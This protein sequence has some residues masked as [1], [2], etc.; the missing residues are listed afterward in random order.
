MHREQDLRITAIIGLCFLLTASGWLSWEYHLMTQIPAVETDLWTMAAGYFLQAAG[1]GLFSVLLRAGEDRADHVLS[2]ALVLHMICMI[3]AVISPH[4]AGTLVFGCLMSLFCGVIAGYYLY[5]LAKNCRE[6][7]KAF[8]FGAGYSISILVQWILSLIGEGAV[9]YSAKILVICLLLT[10][11]VFCVRPNKGVKREVEESEQ[12]ETEKESA[13]GTPVQEGSKPGEQKKAVSEKLLLTAGILVLL[14]SVVNSCGFSFPSAEIGNS[15]NVELSRLVYAGG[16]L[17]AGFAA[18]RNRKYGAVCALA[19]LMIPF[20]ILSLQGE[21]VP[22]LIFWLLSYFAFGF[23]SVYRIILFS[24][25]ASKTNL[26]YISGFGLMIG[27]CGDVLGEIACIS[28]REHL[29]ALVVLTAV[30]FA[31]TVAVFIVAYQLLYMPEAVVQQ[32][33]KEKFYRFS[34]SHDLSSRE[35]DVL[36]LL[37]E[38]K[39]NAEIADVLSISENTVKF[40]V[41]NLLQKTGCRNRKDLLAAY[42]TWIYS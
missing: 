30:L 35:R 3:P 19:A 38:E 26:L 28:L 16:L 10:A 12:R 25:L 8:V 5:D 4:V 31:V 22:S 33:E 29:V 40:H 32:S 14:F 37:L 13:A 9:Y 27:R 2:A 18:D 36:R 20:I 42:I 21:A 17:I 7:Q 1:I 39:T 24:D 23:Y 11:A 34:L 6:D 15:V 41:R